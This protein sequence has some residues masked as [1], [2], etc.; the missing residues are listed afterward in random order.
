M[1]CFKLPKIDSVVFF[2]KYRAVIKESEMIGAR[3]E[4]AFNP[5]H[6]CSPNFANA[7]PAS[8]GPIVTAALNWIELSAMAFG[9]SSRLTR[10]GIS[11]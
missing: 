5:K 9:M 11:A 4:S 2:G 10:L 1:P 6:H 3:N 8:A 7:C